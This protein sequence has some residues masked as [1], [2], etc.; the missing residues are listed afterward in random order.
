MYLLGGPMMTD[1]TVCCG[2]SGDNVTLGVVADAGRQGPG[3][4]LQT[5]VSNELRHWG[6]APHVW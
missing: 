4:S 1:L 2:R 5:R 3:G 6:L